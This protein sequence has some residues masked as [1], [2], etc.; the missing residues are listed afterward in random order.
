VLGGI[1]TD[2]LSLRVGFFI[3]VPF[4]IAMMLAAPRYLVE[5]KKRPGRFD[6]AGTLPR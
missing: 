1:L 5:T 3:N 2:W 6:L 4:G